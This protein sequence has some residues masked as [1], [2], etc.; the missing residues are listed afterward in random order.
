MKEHIGQSGSNQSTMESRIEKLM[1]VV[2]GI[3]DQKMPT[4]DH[5]D[6]DT[7]EVVT[8]N[9][10]CTAQDAETTNSHRT[11]SLASS[12]SG[13]R[14][15]EESRLS[16]SSLGTVS[17]DTE[18]TG[19]IQ[20]PEH[21]RQRSSR[22]KKSRLPESIRR[23]LD[24]QRFSQLHQNND[25]VEHSS[26]SSVAV[27]PASPPSVPQSPT[28]LT[29]TA[30]DDLLLTPRSPTP[31]D[32]LLTPRSPTPPPSP[33]HPDPESQYTEKFSPQQTQKSLQIKKVTPLIVGARHHES[34]SVIYT[35]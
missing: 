17:M 9:L 7:K 3:M 24:H 2:V 18:S 11:D 22:K 8:D 4:M 28:G 16:G 25:H 15:S 29:T 13:S 31:P 6:Q 34:T 21:K 20:S 19:N 14:S 5:E 12:G 23:H 32:D 27:S 30:D 10:V 1:S 33:T 26:E 35:E